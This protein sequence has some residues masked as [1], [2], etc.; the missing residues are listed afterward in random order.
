MYTRL[1]GRGRPTAFTPH[2]AIRIFIAEASGSC[3]PKDARK[4]SSQQKTR[5]D[6]PKYM[7]AMTTE[8]DT[9]PAVD[10]V[11]YRYRTLP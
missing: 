5:D 4:R 1:L 7:K 6:D 9:C 10:P 3:L 2:D 11:I 8:E